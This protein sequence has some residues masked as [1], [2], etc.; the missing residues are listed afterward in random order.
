M[1][2]IATAVWRSDAASPK[3]VIATTAMYRPAQ[4]TARSA[5]DVG[6]GDVQVLT[7]QQYLTQ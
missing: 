6:D 4:V 7:A 1:A 5:W 2:D 3:P